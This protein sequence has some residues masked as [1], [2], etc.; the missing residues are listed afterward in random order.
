MRYK[1][2]LAATALLASGLAF[3][4]PAEAAPASTQKLPEC[5]PAVPAKLVMRRR[6]T[7][8]TVGLGASCP[9]TLYNAD[10]KGIKP[11]DPEQTKLEYLNGDHFA[12]LE[13]SAF[14]SPIGAVTWTPTST[15]GTDSEGDDV[16]VLKSVPSVTKYASSATV[17]GKR[18]GGTTTVVATVGYYNPK[19]N[20]FVRWPSKTVTLQYKVPGSTKWLY[21]RKVTTNKVGQAAFTWTPKA[22][23]YYRAVVPTNTTI[24]DFTTAAISK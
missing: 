20:A 21:L 5:K 16:A 9:S 1:S 10:W 3:G 22:T 11:G 8:Y 23:R 7:V 17:S 19:V 24:W 2:L 6:T 18:V 13:L 12:Q 4:T 15:Y 14:V